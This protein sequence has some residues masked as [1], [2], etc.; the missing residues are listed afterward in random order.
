MTNDPSAR[1]V[2]MGGPLT[3]SRAASL[4]AQLIE[5]FDSADSIHID[6]SAAID[7]DVSFLQMLVAAQK[8]A[9]F[10]GKTLTVSAS[11]MLA[12]QIERCGLDRSAL[13]SFQ[14]TCA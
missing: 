2:V 11:S 1:D 9:V 10:E 5:A 6:L 3:V 8:S 13:P 7:L 12:R 14:D 4:Q